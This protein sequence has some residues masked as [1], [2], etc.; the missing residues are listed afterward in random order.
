MANADV[1]LEIRGLTKR[2]G[3]ATAVSGLDLAVRAGDV[4]GFLGPNGAGKTTTIR[5][6]LG[7]VRPS[8][9]SVRILGHDVATQFR[10]AIAH[11][12]ALVERPAFYPYLTGRANL[13]L[14]ARLAHLG[15]D[16]VDAAL[17][18]VRLAAAAAED[19]RYGTY[20]QGMRQQLGIALALLGTPRLVV[21]D[22]PMNGLDPEA[23]RAVRTLVRRLAAEHGTT[24][25]VSSHL[26]HEV[27]TTCNRV[28]I[29]N[30]GKLVIDGNVD[31]L[32]QPAIVDVRV[33]VTPLD[34]AI[35]CLRAGG[36]DG[37]TRVEDGVVHVR[38]RAEDLAS[39]NERLVRSGF[40]VSELAPLRPTL[41]D[42]FLERTRADGKPDASSS[43]R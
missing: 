19:R 40:R 28:A 32:L 16:A 15:D 36:F 41:E 18:G 20:S 26:L 22:E 5:C 6:A 23:V 35:E 17:D 7:L 21:L 14:F 9:G 3:R 29:L 42:F 1:V 25:L 43:R 33:R 13:R 12:G 31:E 8:E 39:L 2:Y 38:A 24:F 34:A 37:A 10:D 30:A 4:Y 27:E 11:V